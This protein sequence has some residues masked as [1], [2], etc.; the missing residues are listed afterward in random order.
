MS[1][2]VIQHVKTSHHTSDHAE[3]LG[4]SCHSS[5]FACFAAAESGGAS[6][7]DFEPQLVVDPGFYQSCEPKMHAYC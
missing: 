5:P 4:N 3:I 2:Q 6:S 1:L 7:H